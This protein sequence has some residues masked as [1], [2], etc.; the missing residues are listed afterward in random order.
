MQVSIAQQLT[1]I[2]N[3]SS[4]STRSFSINASTG[5]SVSATGTSTPGVVTQ[6]TASAVLLPGSNLATG[7]A[8]SSSTCIGTLNGIGTDSSAMSVRGASSS[9][10]ILLDPKSIFTSSVDTKDAD[11]NLPQSSGNASAS[12]NATSNL[13]V[14]EQQGVYSNTLQTVY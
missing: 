1:N 10:N 8:C 12:F 13:T 9:Q 2:T 3:T 7:V 11:K 5:F 4:G 14:V 6:S